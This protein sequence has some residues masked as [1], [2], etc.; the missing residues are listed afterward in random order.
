MMWKAFG[1]FA[2]ACILWSVE[3]M[4]ATNVS[5]YTDN[6]ESYTNGTPLIDDVSNK[7]WYGSSAEIVVQTNVHADLSTNAAMIPIDCTLSNRCGTNV[8]TTST[9]I[10]IRMQPRVVYYTGSN[11][12]SYDANSTA[13][14][15]VDT[16]GHFVVRNGTSSWVT[17]S[18]TLGGEAYQI[19]ETNFTL[20]DVY[21]S[22]TSK[23]WRL[24]ANSIIIT[25]NISF[26]NTNATNLVG[27]DIYNAGLSSSYVD[28]VYVYDSDMLPTLSVSPSSL[29]NAPFYQ[30]NAT[31]QTFEVRSRGEGQLNYSIITNTDAAWVMITNNAVGGLTNNAANTVYLHYDTAAMSPG[32]Y[33]SSFNVVSTNFEGQTQTVQMVLSIRGMT[34][35]TTNLNSSRML[36]YA[37]DTQSFNVIQTGTGQVTYA[38]TT[39]PA[40]AWLSVS[41]GSGVLTND[42]R[43]TNYVS[44][45]TNG[46]VVGSTSTVLKVATPDGGGVTQLVTVAM[47]NYSRP[48]PTASFSNYSQTIQKGQQPTDTNLYVRNNGSAPRPYMNYAVTSDVS[49]LTVNTNGT[50]TNAE[51]QLV[52]VSFA[53]M[54]TNSGLYTGHLTV[55]GTDAGPSGSYTPTGLVTV[56]TQVTVQVLIIAPGKPSSVSATKGTLADGVQLSWNTTTNLNHFEVWRGTNSSITYATRIESSVSSNTTSYSDTSIMPGIISYYW[57]RVVNNYGGSGDYSDADTGWRYLQASTGLTASDGL[58]TNRVALGWTASY[59]ANTYQVWRSTIDLTNTASLVGTVSSSLTSYDDTSAVVET[60]YYYWIK[61]CTPYMGTFGSSETGYRAALMQPTGLIASDGEF[62]NKVRV[63]WQAVDNASSYEVWRN[64]AD[65]RSGAIK[66]GEPTASGYD[67]E[68]AT[69]GTY[70]YYWIRALNYEGY[71]RYSDP[72]AGWRQL[73]PPTGIS[74]T[75]GTYPYRIRVSWNASDSAVSYEVWRGQGTGVGPGANVTYMKL[76]DITTTYYD[77]HAVVNS[78]PYYYKVKANGPISGGSDYSASDYGWR[79]IS[80]ATT[81]RA[82]KNDYDGDHLSDLTLYNSTSGVF[83]IVCSYIGEYTFTF[84]IA[85]GEGVHGDYDGDGRGDPMVYWPGSGAWLV[86]LSSINYSPLIAGSFGSGGVADPAVA[87]FDGDLVTDLV[88][89]NESAGTMSVL[90][91]NQGAFNVAVTVPMGGSGWWPASA[92]YDGDAKSDPAVYSAADGL[93]VA[94]LSASGYT[95]V[96]VPIGGPGMTF[97][98]A[99]Y[100]GDAKADLVTY[101]EAGGAWVAKISSAGYAAIPVAMGGTGYKPMIAD[102]DGDAK[103]DPALYNESTGAWLIKFSASGYPTIEDNFGGTNWTAV[104][105]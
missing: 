64:T 55:R 23:T 46:L 66:V 103:T 90:L 4:A 14:F 18:Q 59:G 60:V 42:E 93:L 72:D 65:D 33:Y 76:A 35:S 16:N 44:Y 56:S 26:I 61:S 7:Y 34:V 89:Y 68:A 52:V 19:A 70:L 51:N 39:N 50:T 77:D 58:Y 87:D 86:M 102:Y 10:W 40:V 13:I 92:D 36:G 81:T 57:V 53:D 3:A 79:E 29:T 21:L 91:S 71:S 24:S 32:L 104:G 101:A 78:T 80:A 12:P 38:I 75:D 15:H 2:M 100:D 67:D 20:I 83:K 1:L 63:I 94:K 62:T 45:F 84:G 69:Q 9:N 5:L 73:V 30:V 95:T 27:F 96:V 74:A 11:N 37:A 22:Y 31:D 48:V 85:D 88:V 25:N 41:P 6:F 99:D 28:N 17:V 98:P 97:H 49:W 43:S 105:K 82:V 47:T 54:S 8:A